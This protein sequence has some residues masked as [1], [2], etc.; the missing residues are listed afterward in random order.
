MNTN[1]QTVEERLDEHERQIKLLIQ[2]Y[3]RLSNS[4]YLPP[5]DKFELV[6]HNAG[7]YECLSCHKYMKIEH[8][9]IHKCNNEQ[10]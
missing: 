5:D 8:T 9:R 3:T 2:Q 4:I 7:I 10:Q 6:G 1:K